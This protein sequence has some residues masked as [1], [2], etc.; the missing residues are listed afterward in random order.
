MAIEPDDS[1]VR[2]YLA[3]LEAQARAGSGEQSRAAPSGISSGS[4]GYG[5]GGPTWLDAFQS[6]RPPT[7][8]ELVNAY[9]SVAYACIKLNANG[10]AKVPLRLYVKTGRGDARPRRSVRP[11]SRAMNERLRGNP[12]LARTIGSDDTIEEVTE[13]QYLDAFAKPNPFFD[14]NL[15][16][17]YMSISLDVTGSFY[18]YPVRPDPSYACREMWPLQ[19]QYV[20]P[21]KGTGAELLE[22]YRYFGDTFRPDELVRIRTVSMRDPYLSAYAP[23]HACFEQTGLGDYYTATAEQLLRG[24]ARPEILV[25]P[26]DPALPWG[27]D[28][29]QRIEADVNNK[30]ARGR[31]GRVWFTDGSFDAQVLSYGPADLSG[32]EITKW[33]RLMAANCF[34]VPISLLQ[35]ED[36]NK[37]VAS[38]GT[39]QHQ[40]YAIEPRCR[41]IAAALTAQLAEPVNPRLFFAFDDPVSRDI[42]REARVFDMELKNGKRTINEG[43]AECNLPPVPWGNEPWFPNTLVQ[44]SQAAADRERQAKLDEQAA[45][46]PPKPDPNET[47]DPGED[48]VDDAKRSFLLGQLAQLVGQLADRPGPGDGGGRHL[49][50]EGDA[51]RGLDGPARGEHIR[52][53]GWAADQGGAPEVV[54]DAS[55]EGPGDDAVHRGTTSELLPPADGLRRPDGGG[56]DAAAVGLLGRGGEDDQGEAGAGS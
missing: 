40:Y 23:L 35:A 13:H 31:L 30:H 27:E 38:E 56:D 50:P 15:L 18:L 54:R 4:I 14:G 21:I 39:H 6:K 42:E 3:G 46:S 41:A 36:S 12:E 7:P 22:E 55:E 10:V 28:E 26:K 5:S 47:P 51:R 33:E 43:R 34:D 2:A 44:P 45:K 17:L 52:P 24:G 49:H 9:K 53:A 29:R 32:L 1:E 19:S 11:I 16:K 8:I 48:T 20:M 25:G 37:A